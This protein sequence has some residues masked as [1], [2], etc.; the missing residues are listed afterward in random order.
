MPARLGEDAES[1]KDIKGLTAEVDG[2]A[3]APLRAT[4]SP[5]Q[6]PGSVAWWWNSNTL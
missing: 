2:V 3:A 4:E 5:R 6:L 1:V